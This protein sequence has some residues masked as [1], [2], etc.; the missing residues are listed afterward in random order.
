MAI[1]IVEKDSAVLNTKNEEHIPCQTSHTQMFKF[2][3]P[4]HDTYKKIYKRILRMM[5]RYTERLATSHCTYQIAHSVS[6]ANHGAK[7]R[8][9][10]SRIVIG[11]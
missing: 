5:E 2:D 7:V 6:H 11:M 3:S 4:D 10:H 9:L 1:K 8:L